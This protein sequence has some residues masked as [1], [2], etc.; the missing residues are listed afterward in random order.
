[1][2]KFYHVLLLGGVL[3]LH[4][5]I[6]GYTLDQMQYPHDNKHSFIVPKKLKRVVFLNKIE[7]MRAA[8]IL[9]ISGYIEFF[10]F[11]F[12]AIIYAVSSG[13]I[14]KEGLNLIFTVLLSFNTLWFLFSGI[15]YG[16]WS[17]FFKKK[18]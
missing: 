10:I 13:L 6:L 3:L 17:K 9:E 5:I 12:I 2:N 15:F 7:C 18:R 4:A 11:F 8:F 1:M 14:R 16:I